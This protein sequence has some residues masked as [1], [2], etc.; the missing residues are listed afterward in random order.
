MC[1]YKLSRLSSSRWWDQ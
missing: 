1:R